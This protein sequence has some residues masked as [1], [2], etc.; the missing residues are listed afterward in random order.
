VPA[1]PG[2]PDPRGPGEADRYRQIRD[3]LNSMMLNLGEAEYSDPGTR[4]ARF[5]TAAGSSNEARVGV[6][7]AR[8]WGYVTEPMVQQ[9]LAELD[10]VI[11]T[12][13]KLTH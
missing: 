12:L 10:R 11:A 9:G 8:A 4:K 7:A 5:H 6:M 3:A 1:D 13:W 2:R